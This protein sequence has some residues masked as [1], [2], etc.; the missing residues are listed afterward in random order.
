MQEAHFDVHGNDSYNACGTS[1]FLWD[2]GQAG[3]WIKIHHNIFFS[4]NNSHILIRGVPTSTVAEGG[5][6][7]IYNNDFAPNI[8]KIAT[9]DNLGSLYTTAAVLF[10]D[11][12]IIDEDNFNKFVA[13]Y[14]NY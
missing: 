12:N 11:Q 5:G 10:T 3:N 9:C 2:H 13:I 8:N 1:G 14:D 4:S 7:R 6:Y